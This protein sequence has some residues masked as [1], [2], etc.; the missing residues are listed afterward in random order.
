M[1]GREYVRGFLSFFSGEMEIFQLTFF[2]HS[3]VKKSPEE[4]EKV[5]SCLG[6]DALKLVVIKLV[7]K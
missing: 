1:Y 3:G 4:I 7:S 5:F 2:L 6:D